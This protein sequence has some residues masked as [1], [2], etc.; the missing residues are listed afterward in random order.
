[1][2]WWIGIGACLL[3]F[4]VWADHRTR[5]RGNH[6]SRGGHDLPTGKYI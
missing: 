2:W 1:M 6:D 3:L 4:L 5:G